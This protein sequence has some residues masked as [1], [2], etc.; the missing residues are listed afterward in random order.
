MYRMGSRVSLRS[1]G[2]RKVGL[3]PVAR[4]SEATE[5]PNQFLTFAG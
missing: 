3:S 1:P 4:M 2:L 5:L